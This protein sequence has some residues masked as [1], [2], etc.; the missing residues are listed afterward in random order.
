MNIADW[1]MIV[2][3]LLAPVVA[4]QVQKALERYRDDR[5]RKIGVF[6]TLMATR[7]ATVSPLHVQ[8]LNT[9]DLEFHGKKYKSVTD[10]WKTYLDHLNHYP[11]EEEKQQ[12]V[13][14]E[15]SADL[16]A[17]LLMEMGKSLGYIFDEVHVRRA[18][19][20]PQAHANIEKEN[21]L[22][23]QGLVRLLYGDVHLKMDV[24][25]FPVT[26]E[27]INEQK[28]LRKGLQELMDGKRTLGVT[29]SDSD[30]TKDESGK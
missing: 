5:A 30:S 13:W 12:L 9:I 22:I 29:V 4:V 2:A 20:A 8:A 1:L 24:T 28:A 3:V 6:K 16:L 17:K 23:R 26:E 19:Y 27:A 15:R 25:S 18:I 10:S 11:T 7:A 14:G 21:L